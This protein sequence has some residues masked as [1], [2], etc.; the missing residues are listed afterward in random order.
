MNER[1]LEYKG[2]DD[3]KFSRD[4]WRIVSVTVSAI[5]GIVIAWEFFF[6]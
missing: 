6:R 3:L 5:L 2:R 1:I 4:M